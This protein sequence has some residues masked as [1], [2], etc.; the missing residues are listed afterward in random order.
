MDI[1]SNILYAK[2]HLV[3]TIYS[4]VKV[5]GLAAT[6]PETKTIIEG[7]KIE[8][9]PFNEVNFVND[10]K[11]AWEYALDHV[12]DEVCLET[13]KNLNKIAGKF[14]VINSGH[15]R[16][17]FDDPIC[18][19]NSK[20]ENVWTPPIPPKDETIDAAIRDI[21]GD[22]N[23]TEAA[24]NLFLYIAKGQFFN[25]G[26]K[27]TANIAT[28]MIMIKN[29]LGLFSIPQD[30]ILKFNKGLIEYYQTDD[31]QNIKKLFYESC[32]H[33]PVSHPIGIRIQK[34]REYNNISRKDMAA[35]L[36]V[37]ESDLFDIE[38]G[39]KIPDPIIV[40]KISD[41]FNISPKQIDP[42][43]KPVLRSL[44]DQ[45]AIIEAKHTKGLIKKSSHVPDHNSNDIE[46]S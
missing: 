40:E 34:I 24:L 27:R 21:C 42:Q 23:K 9:I 36:S 1:N 39:A 18:I 7:G 13:V 43:Y 5:E 16:D 22:K 46:L 37:K 8:G 2:K 3:E 14:T 10:L 25:D 33:R 26:N 44:D 45:I 30:K 4:S 11:H 15:I 19:Y 17:Y 20:G 31:P 29:G 35:I 32:L 28:N 38:K 6:F 41:Y 12:K